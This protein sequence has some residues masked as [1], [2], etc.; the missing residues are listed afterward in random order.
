MGVNTKEISKMISD[1]AKGLNA[2]PMEIHTTATLRWV[3]LMVRE[4]IHGATERFMMVNGIKD[5]S[6]V[7][8]FGEGFTMIPTLESGDNQRQK[9]MECILGRMAIDMKVSGSNV[10][11]MVKE[12]IYLQMVISTLESIKMESQKA[13]VNILG[14]MAHSTLVSLR[15]A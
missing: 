9:A 1:M 15:M 8:E 3:K 13:K 7:M 10:S 14:V 2:I 5:S 11:N 12:Q 6:M 4:Y